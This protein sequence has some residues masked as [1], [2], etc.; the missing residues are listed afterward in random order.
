ME[1]K[2]ETASIRLLDIF[3]EIE[4]QCFDQEAFTKR[5]LAYLLT[6]YNTIGLVAKAD[7]EIAGFIISQVE[8]EN[9]NLFGHIITINVAPN[10]R[11]KRIG[12]KMLGEIEQILREKGINECHLEVREDNIAALKLYKNSGYRRIV[13]LEK[14]YGNKHGLFLKKIL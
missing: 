13:R 5:Q 7:K 12:T 11:R 2:I 6:D 10:F 9:D 14:Y 8:T 4:N 3:C 1:I